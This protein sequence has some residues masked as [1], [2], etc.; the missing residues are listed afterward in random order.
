M[1]QYVPVY[2]MHLFQVGTASGHMDADLH[3]VS[4]GQVNRAHLYKSNIQSGTENVGIRK[5]RYRN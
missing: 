3:Q 5:V 1:M 2:K 4:Q